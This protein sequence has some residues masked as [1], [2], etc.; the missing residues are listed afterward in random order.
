MALILLLALVW[1]V[2]LVKVVMPWAGWPLGVCFRWT[3][4]TWREVHGDPRRLPPSH[5]PWE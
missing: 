1:F 5:R 2:F 3:I 4:N